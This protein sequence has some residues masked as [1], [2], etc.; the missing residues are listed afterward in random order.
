ML[1]G[2]NYYYKSNCICSGLITAYI[3]ESPLSSTLF[4]FTFF[5]LSVNTWSLLRS[6][7]SW[8]QKKLTQF[9]H[10]HVDPPITRVLSQSRVISSS[11]LSPAVC[12]VQLSMKGDS[13]FLSLYKQKIQDLITAAF[14]DVTVVKLWVF[15]FHRIIIGKK[16][17]FNLI[18]GPAGWKQVH[19][20]PNKSS[21]MAFCKTC[22]LQTL[23][24]TTSLYAHSTLN[25]NLL[26]FLSTNYY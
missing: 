7:N 2:F 5:F 4:S 20:F 14:F 22:I 23:H 24:P 15:F 19:Y 6:Q 18:K 10:K 3:F 16:K 8:Q 25:M 12:P 11:S 21:S 13:S 9:P 1:H 17:S 26:S